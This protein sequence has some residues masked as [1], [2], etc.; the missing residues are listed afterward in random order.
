MNKKTNACFC[1]N[2]NK[3]NN[4]LVE[5]SPSVIICDECIE[6]GSEFVKSQKALAEAKTTNEQKKNNHQIA[7]DEIKKLQKPS[8]LITILDKVV[9][10]QDSAKKQLCSAIYEHK[11]RVILNSLGLGDKLKKSNLFLVGHTGCGKTLLAQTLAKNSDLPIVIEDATKFSKTGYV[12]EDVESMVTALYNKCDNDIAKAEAGGI[13]FV[14]EICKIA[15]RSSLNSED[16]AGDGVQAALLKMVEGADIRI[17]DGAKRGDRQSKTINTSNILFIVSGAFDDMDKLKKSEGRNGQCGFLKSEKIANENK[18]I[19]AD[20]IVKYGFKREFVGRFNTIVQVD[21]LT[22]ED[23]KAIISNP[24]Y[25]SMVSEKIMAEMDG[26]DLTIT[27]EA[28]DL[29]ANLVHKTKFGARAID[30]YLQMLLA[31]FKCNSP[32]WGIDSFVI[33]K[34]LVEQTKLI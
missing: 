32:D 14:D 12:G 30:G 16:P 17:G 6:S 21:N 18:T 25:G 3:T 33:D 10:G 8:E 22:V 23:I 27:D 7:K 13:I 1:G 28:I 4:L 2:T 5:F 11:K 9:M 34:K 29:I 24:N 20:D 19:T 26:I 31:D 15:K